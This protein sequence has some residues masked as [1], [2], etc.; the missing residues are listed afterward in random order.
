MLIVLLSPYIGHL[1]L[2]QVLFFRLS[3]RSRVIS[4]SCSGSYFRHRTS[5]AQIPSTSSHTERIFV[6]T[7][8][9]YTTLLQQP[10]GMEIQTTSDRQNCSIIISQI[11][12]GGLLHDAVTAWAPSCAK[13]FRFYKSVSINQNYTEFSFLWRFVTPAWSLN[14]ARPAAVLQVYICNVIIW[15]LCTF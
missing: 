1:A 5:P 6:Q 14:C 4:D 8:S 11:Y 10:W 15:K 12:A 3:L 7:V 2:A 13:F 9:G